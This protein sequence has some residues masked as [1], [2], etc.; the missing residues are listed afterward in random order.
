MME[1]TPIHLVSFCKEVSVS[2]SVWTIHKDGQVLAVAN[3]DG[4][5]V[6][7]SW[8]S[9]DRVVN[10]LKEVDGFEAFTPLEIPLVLFKT[11]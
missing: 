2:N 6:I 4:Y 10:F 1:P 9:R 5:N 7:P 11:K 8:S 3:A